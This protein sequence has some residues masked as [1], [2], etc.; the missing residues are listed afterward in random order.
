MSSIFWIIFWC[1]SIA[2]RSLTI[3]VNRWICVFPD[4]VP[5]G[6]AYG[7]WRQLFKGV[8]VFSAD[9]VTQRVSLPFSRK[10][11][12]T[13]SLWQF[14][15]NQLR[16]IGSWERGLNEN[17][18]GLLRQYF[19]KGMELI[20]VTQ[21]QGQW[22]V[23]RLNHRPCKVLGFRTPFQMFF[24]KTVCYTKPP[25]GV[26]LQNWIRVTISTRKHMDI[27]TFPVVMII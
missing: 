27:L 14:Y 5:C 10:P 1:F 26:A 3:Q 15:R 4:I 9:T 20:E 23:D 11:S 13:I 18:N 17:S 2:W 8:R 19:P 12:S 22:A 16:K 25:L 6:C 7:V 24:G 21:E